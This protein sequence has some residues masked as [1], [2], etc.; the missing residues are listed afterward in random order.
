MCASGYRCDCSAHCIC[1]CQ[2]EKDGKQSKLVAVDFYLTSPSCS[3]MTLICAPV[4]VRP[5]PL[6]PRGP[7]P[8]HIIADRRLA[9]WPCP[10]LSHAA[11]PPSSSESSHSTDVGRRAPVCS[12]L[13][14]A[15][16]PSG[17][18]ITAVYTRCLAPARTI[19]LKFSA[20]SLERMLMSVAPP[21]SDEPL[22][23]VRPRIEAVA[24]SAI[25]VR[26]TVDAR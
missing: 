3:F 6:A 17:A 16:G 20:G 22:A 14:T 1:L 2:D 4:L 23:W 11:R 25:I 24:A 7:R 19:E 12:P 13:W 5:L 9:S 8:R 21:S 26:V 10:Q 18:D 15:R